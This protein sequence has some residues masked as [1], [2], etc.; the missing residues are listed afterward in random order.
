MRADDRSGEGNPT[1]LAARVGDAA[2]TV[3]AS[4]ANIP[5]MA[6][7]PLQAAHHANRGID[8]SQNHL[9]PS[10]WPKFA[11]GPTG[12]FAI[13]SADGAFKHH[14]PVGKQWLVSWGLRGH[15]QRTRW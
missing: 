2:N 10:A 3:L 14:C 4:I 8:Q 1:A 15:P 13:G 6:S 7:G 5:V 12:I 11:I 9:G